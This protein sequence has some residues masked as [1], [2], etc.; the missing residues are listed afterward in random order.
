MDNE[1]FR[2]ELQ[3]L[4]NDMRTNNEFG[5]V[6]EEYNC[7]ISSLTEKHAPLLKRK[8]KVVQNAPWFDEEYRLLRAQRRSTERKYKQ[9]HL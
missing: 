1:Q 8:I 5:N 7:K 3:P 4:V 9:S 2:N 6:V